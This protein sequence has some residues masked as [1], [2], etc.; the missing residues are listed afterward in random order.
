MGTSSRV[1]E[2]L[3]KPLLE[4]ETV[5]SSVYSDHDPITSKATKAQL[6]AA[7]AVATCVTAGAV[8]SIVSFLMYPVAI[9]YIAGQCL[10]VSLTTICTTFFN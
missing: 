5:T 9:M 7:G 10:F 8:S 6:L 2:E 4:T 1:D 3:N